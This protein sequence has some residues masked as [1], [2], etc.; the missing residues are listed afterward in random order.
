MEVNGVFPWSD[1]INGMKDY[2]IEA[3]REGTKRKEIAAKLT[4]S[5]KIIEGREA[6][7]MQALEKSHKER[8][9]MISS[10]TKTL[11]IASENGDTQLA[12]ITMQA[13]VAFSASAPPLPSLGTNSDIPLLEKE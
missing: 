2:L 11:D 9:Q 13:L 1:L 3:K 5:L 7:A 8:M 4:A 12:T 10:L 6:L